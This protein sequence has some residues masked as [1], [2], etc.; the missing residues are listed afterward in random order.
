M[1][2]KRRPRAP[3]WARMTLYVCLAALYIP[4]IMML[5]GAV[6]VPEEAI[7]LAAGNGK[8]WTL[9]WFGEVL[10]D[11]ELM[12]AFANSLMVA[13]AS[14][15]GATVLGTAACIALYKSNFKGK[16]WLENLNLVALVFPEIVFALSLLSLFFILGLGL[17]LTSVIIAHVTFCLSYVMM[18][19]SARLSVLDKSLDEAAQDLGASDF[20]ILRTIILPLLKPGILGGFILSFL[21]SFDD[22]LITYF[23]N[24]VGTDTLPVKLYTAMKMGVSPKLNALSSLMFLGTLSVLIFLFRSASFRD[25]FEGG[26]KKNGSQESS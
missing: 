26:G 2:E 3:W 19:V 8:V 7:G 21:I 6:W 10:A 9:R 16:K 20:Y 12:R 23:V 11:F 13:V 25:L 14:S 18:T 24:G 15:I 1:N 17:G 4:L 5:I 22:F